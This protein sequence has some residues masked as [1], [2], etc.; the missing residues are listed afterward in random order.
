LLDICANDGPDRLA[1]IVGPVL[2]ARARDRMPDIGHGAGQMAFKR[3]APRDAGHGPAARMARHNAER[4][5]K[6][7]HGILDGADRVAVADAPATRTT[8]MSPMP[9]SKRSRR[10][11]ASRSNRRRPRNG[12]VHVPP[13]QI[14][15]MRRPADVRS[16]PG[17][18]ERSPPS[19]MPRHRST[20]VPVLPP[21]LR[22]LLG[23][24]P[25]GTTYYDTATVEL[26]IQ[27]T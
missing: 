5:V 7:L 10:G 12:A 13:S 8:K 22:P 23:F 11:F 26:L 25:W 18:T 9:W 27:P 14:F 4:N 15:S 21:C 2:V 1:F 16:P 19:A 3:D 24:T 6:V 20:C 17:R